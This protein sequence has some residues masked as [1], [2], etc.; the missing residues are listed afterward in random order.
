MK[1][2][3]RLKQAV[4]GRNILLVI[5]LLFTV[6]LWSSSAVAAD[7]DFS[8]NWTLDEE[9]SDIGEGRFR[10][11]RT[12]EVKQDK[13]NLK[14]VM[15][16]RGR[17]GQERRME[18]VY[19]LDGKETTSGE[20]GRSTISTVK[21]SEDGKS[22]II[23][24]KRIRTRNGETSEIKTDETWTLRKDGKVLTIQS[25]TSSPRGESSAKLVYNLG[26]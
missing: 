14:V 6:C 13:V 22:L 26:S 1:R 7:P 3:S 25:K 18:S 5:S 2:N 23:H 11:S 8:G 9:Q 20:E 19:S 21:W 15:F 10:P 17:D 12:L 16:R 24:A 4:S